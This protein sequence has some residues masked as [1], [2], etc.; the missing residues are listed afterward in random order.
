MRNNGLQ[1][2]IALDQVLN[3]LIGKG[4]ADET[5]SARA[6]RCRN[7]TKAWNW[8]YRTIDKIFFW[9]DDHCYIAHLREMTRAQLPPEYRHKDES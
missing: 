1:F 9:Q 2:L 6:Y 3:T 7:K 4:W 5:L 8:A